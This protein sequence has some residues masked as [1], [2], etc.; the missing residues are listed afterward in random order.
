MAINAWQHKPSWADCS[1]WIPCS[2]TVSRSS[3]AYCS[4]NPIPTAQLFVEIRSRLEYRPG[5]SLLRT[6]VIPV[7]CQSTVGYL[8][9]GSQHQPRP[10]ACQLLARNDHDSLRRRS[11]G[12]RWSYVSADRLVGLVRPSRAVLI[13]APMLNH[14]KSKLPAKGDVP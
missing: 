12:L 6:H 4:V 3:R 5:A 11:I 8:V 7:N 9:L 10:K 13:A 1:P 14:A 2:C